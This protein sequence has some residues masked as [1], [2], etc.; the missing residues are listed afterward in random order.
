VDEEPPPPLDCDSKVIKPVPIPL[1]PGQTNKSKE[2]KQ[3]EANAIIQMMT[4]LWSWVPKL[5]RFSL[6]P[7]PETQLLP[8]IFSVVHIDQVA[9]LGRCCDCALYLASLICKH[10]C[11]WS[12]L[13]CTVQYTCISI[14]FD[15]LAVLKWFVESHTWSPTSKVIC[16]PPPYFVCRC[17]AWSNYSCRIRWVPSSL[18]STA[19]DS[20]SHFKLAGALRAFNSIWVLQWYTTQNW[21]IHVEAW[22]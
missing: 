6:L 13:L 5:N 14:F 3:G 9:T 1:V 20:I 2:V 8:L 12:Y 21:V 16:L 4:F 10:S 18:S 15:S 19:S 22:I 11:W 17:R 7:S